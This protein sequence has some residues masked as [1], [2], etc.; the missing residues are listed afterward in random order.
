MTVR[1]ARWKLYSIL[2]IGT[3][4]VSTA[5]IFIRL[6]MTSA[7]TQGLGFSLVLAAARLGIAALSLSIYFLL[8]HLMSSR[9]ARSI[10]PKQHPVPRQALFYAI[11]AGIFLALHFATWITSLSYTSIAASTTI[12]TTNPIWVA[13]ISRFWLQ[14]KLQGLTWAGMAIALLGGILIGSEDNSTAAT[15]LVAAQPWLGNGLALVGAWTASA[16]LLCGQQAQQ[17]GLEIRPYIAIVYT[18][19][20][21]LLLPLPFLLG[22]SYFGYPAWTYVWMVAMAWVPQLIGHTS[23]NWAVRYLPPTIVTL[24]ILLEPI[25]SSLFAYLF[26]QEIPTQRLILGAMIVLIG[27]AIAAM[28]QTGSGTDRS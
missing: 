21:L 14:E 10:E 24:V 13:L 15:H 19:A 18:T 4:A 28:T 1:P 7:M 26:F 22:L 6:A 17:R 3:I 2:A 23:F 9:S 16:Y 12:V 25:G 8:P 5:A 20:A 11:A 27:V